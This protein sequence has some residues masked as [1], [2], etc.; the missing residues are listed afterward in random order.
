MKRFQSW[1]RYF[2]LLLLV[3]FL[4]GCTQKKPYVVMLSLDGFRWDYADSVPTPNLDYIALQGVKAKSLKPSFPTKTFPNHY[5]LATGLYP[6][7]HGIVHNSFYDP[8]NDREYRIYDREA[9]EDGTFYGGEPLW[10]TA[11]KQQMISASYFWVG[12]EADIQDVRPTYWKEYDGKFPFSNSIDTVIHWL[13]LPVE[14]RPQLVLFYNSEPDYTGHNFGPDDDRVKEK[15][16]YLDSLVGVFLHKL[17]SIPIADQVDFL[18]VSDHGMTGLTDEKSVYLSDYISEEWFERIE[19]YNPIYLLQPKPEFE[20]EAYTALNNMKHVSCWKKDSLPDKWNYGT[21]NRILD[22][23][24]V[25][26]NDWQIRKNRESKGLRGDHGYDND[27]KDM[28]AIF[29]AMG[30]SFKENYVHPTFENIEI[31]NLVC[32][33]LNLQPAENDGKLENVKDLL[34]E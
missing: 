19:G 3:V 11:E 34:R 16:V 30:P 17:E 15:V 24:L 20:T 1:N 5:T 14:K 32:H 8:V 29:Y 28:H 22:F 31:Y 23:V 2:F 12:S 25:A 27:F 21:S 7:H 13:Q 4:S 10:V 6:D 18:L 33:I 9:V 26:E